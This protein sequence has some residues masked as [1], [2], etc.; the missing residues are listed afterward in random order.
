[1]ESRRGSI[2]RLLQGIDS[3]AGPVRGRG[4]GSSAFYQSSSSSS[5]EEGDEEVL[6]KGESLRPAPSSLVEHEVPSSSSSAALNAPAPGSDR[7]SREKEVVEEVPRPAIL[8]MSGDGL[9]PTQRE[10]LE[11]CCDKGEKLD[12]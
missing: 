12:D 5:D 9:S 6:S 8:V 7:Q 2:E 1:M 4:G 10:W 3:T 11:E